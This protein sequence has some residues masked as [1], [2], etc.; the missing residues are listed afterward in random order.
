MSE[1]AALTAPPP[2]APDRREG[3]LARWY[4]RDPIRAAAIGLIVV[5]LAVRAQVGAGGYLVYDDF[6]LAWRA[7]EFDLADL[8]VFVY[9]NH[10]MPGTML[11]TWIVTTVWPMSYA[12]YLV[13]MLV[14]QA[15]LAIAFYRLL[16]QVLPATWGLLIP[17][18]MFL[19][20]PLTLEATTWWAVGGSQLGMLL[21]LALALGAQVKYARTRRNRHLVSLGLS[22]LLGVLFFEKTLLIVPLVF[23]FT[24]CLL[25]EGGPVRSVV[26]AVRRFWRSWLVLGALAGGYVTL[27]IALAPAGARQPANTGEV[28]TFVRE[29]VGST[30]LPGLLGGPWTWIDVG[31]GPPV[32]G[33]PE[34]LRWATWVVFAALVIITMSRRRIAA[35]AWLLLALDVAMTVAL[36]AT[37]RLGGI[38][39]P[40]AGLAPRYVT[41]VVLVG[42]LCVGVALFGLAPGLATAR[43]AARAAVPERPAPSKRTQQWRG[44]AAVALA[45]S[46]VLLIGSAGWTS[47]RFGD[48]WKHKVGRDY[49]ATVQA[50]VAVA[51][52]NEVFFDAVVPD[53]VM[54]ALSAPDN[55]QSRVF[56]LLDP[57]PQFVTAAENPRMFNN[58]GHIRP[59]QIEGVTNRPGPVRDCGYMAQGGRP[60]R[61]ELQQGMAVWR[62]AIKIV[63]LSGGDAPAVVYFGGTTTRFQIRKGV[64]QIILIV[65]GGGES[66]DLTVLDPK[67]TACTNEVTVGTPRP[68]P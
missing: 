25:V 29:I 3:W 40:V 2:P 11:V 60:A 34:V 30:L 48:D 1:S 5:H 26:D 21:A 23:L 18:A 35:R 52:R 45:A 22:F 65:G 16:R 7:A 51:P 13:V 15:V 64:N 54:P 49:L 14:G 56:R 66:V 41:D 27:Y 43:A 4:A 68:Q 17:L 62:W 20:C 67:V 38:Y 9:N 33:T 8:L 37:T 44:A 31:E 6:S 57:R 19:F 24:V 63:Y 42:A 32:T 47:A 10:L 59:V 46:L 50:E 55:L 58:E 28:V 12:P 36:L 53:W 61:V 39:S